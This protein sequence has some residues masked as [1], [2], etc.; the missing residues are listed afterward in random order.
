MGTC[1]SFSPPMINVGVV[2]LATSL[3]GEIRSHAFR[4]HP[5][6]PKLGLPLPLI[7]VVA[8]VGPVENLAGS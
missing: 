4:G 8:V 6:E 5:W 1:Q 3:N 7:V 2:I